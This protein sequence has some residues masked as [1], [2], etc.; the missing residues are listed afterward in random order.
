V[1]VKNAKKAT[2]KKASAKKTES[3]K[4]FVARVTDHKDKLRERLNSARR[5]ETKLAD[6]LDSYAQ[7]F[8]EA[9]DLIKLLENC[10]ARNHD[11]NSDDDED[12]K[13]KFPR[14]AIFT[15]QGHDSYDDCNS[16][17]LYDVKTADLEIH[18]PLIKIL[19][20][21]IARWRREVEKLLKK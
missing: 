15:I 17:E 19:K 16:E 21:N 13:A 14:T 5:A 4:Q 11:N 2:A 18:E 12:S 8:Q 20:E 3:L 7:A 1:A 9:E 6:D 10:E